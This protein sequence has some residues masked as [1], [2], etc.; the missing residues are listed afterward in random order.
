MLSKAM[1][2]LQLHTR[3]SYDATHTENVS[4]MQ[5]VQGIFCF[6]LRHFEATNLELQE[7][8]GICVSLF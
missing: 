2:R 6:Q 8:F 1:S 5:M 7:L 4:V 3:E